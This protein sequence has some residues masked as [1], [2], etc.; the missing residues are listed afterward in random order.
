MTPQV[1]DLRTVG[2]AF[3]ARRHP[4]MVIGAD[5]RRERPVE[6]QRLRPVG[7]RRGEEDRHRTALRHAEE[8]RALD[9]DRVHDRSHVV[10]PR[11]EPGDADRAV[12][13]T[14]PRLSNVVMRANLETR[15][16]PRRGPSPCWRAFGRHS[17]RT[18]ER[19]PRRA[20]RHRR[21][22]T[23]CGR[24]RF[25][26]WIRGA[27]NADCHTDGMPTSPGLSEPLTPGIVKVTRVPREP[28]ADAVIS[29][30]P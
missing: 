20:G 22:R 19:R 7:E 16:R 1:L 28:L 25:A 15:S 23:R 10:H 11:F 14:G 18:R 26:Y 30:D 6:R 5:P 13:E 12:A 27:T 8:V 29:T 9:A 2:R 4:R 24:L 17:R 3:F 21:S